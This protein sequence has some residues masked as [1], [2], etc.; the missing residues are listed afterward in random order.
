MAT[1]TWNENCG[2]TTTEDLPLILWTGGQTV[3]LCY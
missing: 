2:G 3:F 1:S